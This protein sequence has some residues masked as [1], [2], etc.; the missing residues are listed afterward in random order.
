[1]FFSETDTAIMRICLHLWFLTLHPAPGED[2]LSR[3]NIQLCQRL[4]FKKQVFERRCQCDCGAKCE[5]L[6]T[7]VEGEPVEER[8]ASRPGAEG[9][10]GAIE[11]SLC[12]HLAVR[13][14]QLQ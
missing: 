5:N 10:Q 6:A 2:I 12:G 9:E 3:D 8:K 4:S 1:M 7:V 13:A 14:Y 11:Q